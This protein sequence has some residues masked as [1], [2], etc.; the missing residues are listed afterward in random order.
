MAAKQVIPPFSLILAFAFIPL[1]VFSA[2]AVPLERLNSLKVIKSVNK[3]GPFLGL[4]TVYAPEE[5]AFFSTGVFRPDPRHP[6]VD[7]SGKL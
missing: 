2:Q 1:L 5:E 4:V 3:N 6:F 7:L